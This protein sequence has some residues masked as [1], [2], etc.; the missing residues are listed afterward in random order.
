[1]NT[2]QIFNLTIFC[3]VIKRYYEV[4]NQISYVMY[5]YIKFVVLGGNFHCERIMNLFIYINIVSMCLQLDTVH[6][7]SVLNVMAVGLF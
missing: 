2:V 4:K 1:M 7:S 3:F 5:P 6:N